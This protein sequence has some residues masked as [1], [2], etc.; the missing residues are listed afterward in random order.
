[1]IRVTAN[2]QGIDC[3]DADQSG[4]SHSHGH[5][6]G[7]TVV[8]QEHYRR[9]RVN[10]QVSVRRGPANSRGRNLNSQCR[11]ETKD[12]MAHETR[13]TIT[14]IQHIAAMAPQNASALPCKASESFNRQAANNGKAT[15]ARGQITSPKIMTMRGL[16][17]LLPITSIA[18]PAGALHKPTT[19]A[20]M[21]MPLTRRGFP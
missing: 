14:K 7:Q 4:L 16:V 2:A 13:A 15:P 11:N 19:S 10:D 9:E 6:S 21:P 5:Q 20:A 18:K 3:S 12:I 17:S 8:H 1:L